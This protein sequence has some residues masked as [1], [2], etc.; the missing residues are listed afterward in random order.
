MHI[1]GQSSEKRLPAA[2]KFKAA[3]LYMNC[4][5]RFFLYGCR[6]P[7]YEKG[8]IRGQAHFPEGV[9]PGDFAGGCF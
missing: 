5:C 3:A 2:L 7:L 9:A 6:E 8:L 1:W 4:A